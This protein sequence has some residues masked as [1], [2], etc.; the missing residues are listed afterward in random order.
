MRL[1]GGSMFEDL[2]RV[3]NGELT[4]N[5]R[6]LWSGQPKQGL[7]LRTSDL[8]LIPFSLLWGGFAVFWEFG[9][10]K[11]NAP[12]FMRLFGIPFVLI[13]LYITVGRF[14]LDEKQRSTTYY[15][16]TNQRVII[17]SNWFGRKVKSL[18]LKTLSDVSLTEKADRQGTIT[19]GATNILNWWYGGMWWPGMAQQTTPCFELIENA[20][21][22]Y[23]KI[24]SAQNSSG[25]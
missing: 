17:V 3:F 14:F 6:L 5:E 16:V 15:G 13:G 21:E 24:R 2:A 4:S 7:T 23:E 20:K 1:K 11:S 12:F 8:F 19:F 22:V 25:A 10:I 18:N 9:V